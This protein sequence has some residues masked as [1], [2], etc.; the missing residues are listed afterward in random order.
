MG[1]PTPP[2]LEGMEF[3]P[4]IS[5]DPYEHALPVNSIITADLETL[6]GKGGPQTP[7]MAQWYGVKGGQAYGARFEL[8]NYPNPQAM[9]SAFWMSL[10]NHA[11]KCT[12]YFHNW[13]GYDSILSL[14]AL[15]SHRESGLEFNP[16]VRNQ[17][18]IEMARLSPWR[19][20]N[21]LKIN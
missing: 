1:P 11:Q 5:S 4:I 14:A 3:N 2:A 21:H 19:Y 7:F 17:I 13:A 16:V 9:L 8:P 20:V 18:Q 10:I 6:Q 15:L 12:V